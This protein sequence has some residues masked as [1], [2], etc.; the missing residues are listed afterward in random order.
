MAVCRKRFLAEKS[1]RIK[2][3]RGVPR[4]S[5]HKPRS[6]GLFGGFHTAVGFAA[7]KKFRRG[8]AAKDYCG[9]RFRLLLPQYMAF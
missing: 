5:S 2:D 6:A 9:K 3:R 4:R 7:L 8:S 1:T